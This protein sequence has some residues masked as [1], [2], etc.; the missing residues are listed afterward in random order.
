ME[1]TDALG[2]PGDLRWCERLGVEMITD[3]EMQ[4]RGECL[5]DRDFI[6]RTWIRRPALDDSWTIHFAAER[7]IHRRDLRDIRRTRK[8]EQH[9]PAHPDADHARD[10][11]DRFELRRRRSHR[12]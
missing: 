3:A 8:V 2:E 4:L 5:T 12:G 11:P 10:M 9:A 6:D 1:V 7:G